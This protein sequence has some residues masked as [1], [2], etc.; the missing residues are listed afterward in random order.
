[1]TK[2]KYANRARLR[3]EDESVQTEISAYQHHVKR[4]T[5]E[6]AELRNKLAAEQESRKRETQRLRA[7]LDEGLT[8]EILALRKELERQ[9]QR[10]D[11]AERDR[12]QAGEAL[13]RMLVGWGQ[14][15]VAGLGLSRVEATE[16]LMFLDP[17][18]RDVTYAGTLIPQGL[19]ARNITAEGAYDVQAAQRRRRPHTSEDVVMMLQAHMAASAERLRTR[20][21]EWKDCPLSTR[22]E[23]VYEL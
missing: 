9:R 1:V 20:P 8:P 23:A 2:G 10:A 21:C 3:R 11:K 4:L 18:G 12:R 14:L 22:D 16:M 15:L 5:D 6:N 7:Q 17:E 19:I 13:N